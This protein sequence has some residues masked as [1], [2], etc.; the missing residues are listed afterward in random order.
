MKKNFAL[1]FLLTSQIYASDF[2]SCNTEEALVTFSVTE[3]VTDNMHYCVA[4]TKA[5]AF[6]Y[7]SGHALCPLDLETIE[8]M[9]VEFPLINGHDCEIPD[10]I[11]GVVVYDG[12]KI[13]LD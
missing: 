8:R 11:S 1:C 6:S 7:Y 2:K 3:V 4:K 13:F 12:R 10:V 9:G 5:T